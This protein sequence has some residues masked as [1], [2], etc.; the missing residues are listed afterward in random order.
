MRGERGFYIR[1]LLGETLLSV[2][3]Q[4]RIPTMTQKTGGVI[5]TGCG[6]SSVS[7]LLT[8][9]PNSSFIRR[10]RYPTKSQRKPLRHLV[11]T[12][13]MKIA[14]VGLGHVGLPLSLQCAQS[15]VSM[16]RLDVDAKKVQ[17]LNN[18]Q[19]YIRHI[20]PSAIAELVGSGKFSASTEL[21]RIKDVEPVLI[22]VATPLSENREPDISFVIKIGE[23]HRTWRKGH[24]WCLN[25]PL[26]PGRRMRTSAWF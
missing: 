26:I 11:D 1:R 7:A 13:Q 19:S 2:S 18:G 8:I 14:V 24:W 4:F 20:E 6:K 12:E 3:S 10:H 23:S 17:L 9:M 5:V 22:C 16:I 25:Q 15:C 21:S